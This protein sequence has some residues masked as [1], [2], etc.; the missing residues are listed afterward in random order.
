[1]SLDCLQE[2]CISALF[3][4]GL[5][6]CHN[7][8][9]GLPYGGIAVG[10]W[11]AGAKIP[12]SKVPRDNRI[13]NN[14]IAMTHQILGGDGGPIYVIGEQPGGLIGGNYV[15]ASP[16]C[17]FPDQ[18]AAFWTIP[19]SVIETK[20]NWLNISFENTHDISIE[21]NYTNSSNSLNHGTNCI[22]T[23]TH[24]EAAPPWSFEAQAII[25]ASGLEPE[26]RDIVP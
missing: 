9:A 12:P 7:D 19:K 6:V 3:T 13:L 4:V 26:C 1:M 25:D 17:L 18:S 5:T 8:L 21:G 20:G 15:I 10:W 14:R 23:N 2:E 16:R 22:V 24:L 11:W